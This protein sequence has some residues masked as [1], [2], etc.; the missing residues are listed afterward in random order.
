MVIVPMKFLIFDHSTNKGRASSKLE[1]KSVSGKEVIQSLAVNG[2]KQNDPNAV[3]G[4][5]PLPQLHESKLWKSAEDLYNREMA[6]RDRV[7]AELL[8]GVELAEKDDKALAVNELAAFRAAYCLDGIVVKPETSQMYLAATGH[9]RSRAV[10]HAAV[11]RLSGDVQGEESSYPQGLDDIFAI[12][13]EPVQ[14]SGDLERMKFQFN[15]NRGKQFGVTKLDPTDFLLISYELVK[16][17]LSRAQLREF[18]PPSEAQRQHCLAEIEIR[19]PKIK[20]FEKLMLPAEHEDHLPI[21]R[22]KHTWLPRLTAG[23]LETTMKKWN[24]SHTSETADI[25]QQPITRVFT[26]DEVLKFLREQSAVAQ[27]QTIVPGDKWRTQVVETTAFNNPV[28][29]TIGEHHL[30]N[31]LDQ[32]VEYAEDTAQ[33]CA[34]VDSV[35]T[36]V[37]EPMDYWAGFDLIS[38]VDED[39]IQF[40]IQSLELLIGVDPRYFDKV[41]K[42]LQGKQAD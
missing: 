16:E 14:F 26:D 24:K 20:L 40:V 22:M 31:R 38:T 13:I 15:E 12:A 17:G 28:V 32:L 5:T 6:R 2:W 8:E 9:Q 3:I 33:P 10:F 39:R 23:L 30:S 18:F 25:G 35:Y 4:A 27:T 1:P 34:A 29:R 7:H 11:A 41:S 42:Y 36:T 21:K 37:E 19:R